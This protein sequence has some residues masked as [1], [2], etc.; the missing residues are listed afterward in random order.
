MDNIE[1]LFEQETKEKKK[2]S[3]GIHHR[4]SR[5]GRLKGGMRTPVDYLKGEAKKEYMGNSKVKR[6]ILLDNGQMIP[7]EE[8]TYI[9]S[10]R[11]Y[12]EF[13][14][15]DA[16][17]K[18]LFLL[19]QEGKTAGVIAEELGAS[20]NTIYNW[21]NRLSIERTPASMC[22]TKP[23]RRESISMEDTTKTPA[24]KKTKKPR[25]TYT[26]SGEF[27]GAELSERLEAFVLGI[28]KESKYIV[29]IS[30]NEQ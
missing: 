22:R 9:M 27:S 13:K 12:Q 14:A 29:E 19:S 20:K 26:I 21:F 6:Y 23:S 4:A 11:T 5:T 24:D 30:I 3:H 2:I 8:E 16:D 28:R 25:V 10:I 17:G 18:R 1:R 15:L 7:I